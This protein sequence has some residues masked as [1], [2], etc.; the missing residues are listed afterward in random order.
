M[1]LRSND[2]LWDTYIDK[3]PRE[4]QDIYY[5]RQYCKMSELIEGGEAQLFVYEDKDNI[6]LYPYIKHMV[7]Y[8]ERDTL[9]YDIETAYGY[10]GPVV[11]KH[12][13]DFENAF[14]T[15][16]LEYCQTDNIIA[17]FLRFHP[18]LENEKI[19][20]REINVL[21]NRKTVWINLEKSLDEIWM[22]D[23]S[24]QNRNTIKKCVKNGLRV[25][26]SEDY[27]EFLE[28][29]NQTMKKVGA[30]DFYFFGKKYYDSVKIAPCYL[31]MRVRR[32]RET[33]AA[34]IFMEY[35]DYFHY[36]YREV[37]ENF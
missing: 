27:D 33:L 32:D 9:F 7:D 17:E 20:R 30:D 16:F 29:Y 12:D 1:I 36:H 22:Q 6:A 31:L 18:L 5:T 2:R 35:G 8:K 15:A 21:H 10:G 37:G 34:A 23:I 11:K 13:P 28:I 4:K 26:I 3:L 24:T 25:E 19:F 14:E